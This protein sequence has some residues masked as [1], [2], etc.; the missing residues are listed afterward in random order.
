MKRF[1][2]FFLGIGIFA[3]GIACVALLW[4]TKPEAGK[5]EDIISLPVVE[6]LPV[7]VSSETFEI[8]SQGIVKANRRTMLA[9]E[10][11]GKVEEVNPL[12]E[13]GSVVAKGTTLVKVESS[14]YVAALAQ[15]KSDLAEAQSNLASENARALQGSR[16]WRKL[17]TGEAPSD[18]VLRKPQ[19]ASAEARV[20]SARANQQKAER[21]L[22]RTAITAPFDAVI[23]S[24]STEVGSY[25]SPGVTV[26]EL[27][28][29]EPY[30]VHLPL[31][32]DELAFLRSDAKGNL[33]GEVSVTATAAGITRTWPGRVI[34][35]SGEIDRATRSLHLIV[36]I[37]GTSTAGGIVMRPGLFV[38]A[39]IK[40]REIQN[41]VAI[42][43]RAFLDLN[44]VVTVDPDNKLRFRNVTVLHR[45]GDT[46][47]V[48][49]GLSPGEKI[50][51]TELPD[52]V[53]GMSVETKVATS[54]SE[55]SETASDKTSTTQKS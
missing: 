17:G 39:A 48:S 21:D 36:E 40:G 53:E 3:F 14:N 54:D 25:L 8:P 37:G 32:V 31:S 24:T 26:A 2:K 47:Y 23:S 1:L 16:D 22:E 49:D 13:L 44:R 10:V 51:L 9:S 19:L 30:E 45:E 12:F 46:V 4:I 43:F 42:P 6:V 35:T 11:A 18:L 28:E 20:E 33:T 50:C 15:A 7:S 52:M 5:K 55:E 29:T 27:F 34:R 41:V 38:E